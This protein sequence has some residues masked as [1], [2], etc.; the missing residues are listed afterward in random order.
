MN[1]DWIPQNLA[2]IVSRLGEHLILALLPVL[3]GLV[4][5]VPLGWLAEVMITRKPAP[6]RHSASN[7]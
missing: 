7:S 6:S 1:W 5:A 3:I 2:S 4:I